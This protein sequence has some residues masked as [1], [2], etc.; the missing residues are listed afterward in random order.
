MHSDETWLTG[1]NAV[2]AARQ[3]EG[4]PY[5]PSLTGSTTADQAQI[6][7]VYEAVDPKFD[8]AV[9][10]FPQ[11]LQVSQPRSVYVSPVGNTIDTILTEDGVK[12]ALRGERSAEESLQVADQAAQD[13]IE[14]Q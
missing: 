3:A 4:A 12:P 5:V 14:F 2:K 7:Q 8:Q 9:Q 6:D 10:L 13:E 11:L 1:A